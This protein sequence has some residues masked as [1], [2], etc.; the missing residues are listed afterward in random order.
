MG[1]REENATVWR[2]LE[3]KSSTQGAEGRGYA[4]TR[5]D[6]AA[7]QGKGVAHSVTDEACCKAV[8]E[9]ETR[10]RKLKGSY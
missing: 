7:G 1:E 9:V 4:P 2:F 8:E 6:Y 10:L 5:G 3:A